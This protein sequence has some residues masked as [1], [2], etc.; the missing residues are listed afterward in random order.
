MQ[1]SIVLLLVYV[2]AA[3]GLLLGR[4]SG[5]A[6][7]NLKVTWGPNPFGSEYYVKQPLTID[8]AKNE[9]WVQVNNGCQGKFLGQRFVKDKDI[10]L[11]LI[12]GSNGHIAGVQMGI[13][14]SMAKTQYYKFDQQ[15]MFNRDTIAGIDAYI[16]TAY[17]VDPSTICQS[18]GDNKNLK[19]DAVGT[20]LWLQN[21]AD[22]IRDSFSSPLDQSDL[23]KTKWVQGACFP[24]MGVHYWYENRLD[25]D[26]D[27]F[28]PGFLLYTK[29]KLTGFG[30]STVGK[31]EYSKRTEFPPLAAIMSFLKP[32]PTCMPAQFNEVGG[33]T[34]MHLYFNAEPWSIFC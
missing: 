17:F 16:L 9:G 31:Y 24:S 6:W 29:G 23:P 34:T 10:A 2:T 25:A 14:A 5:P 11:V 4:G 15:K 12:Y 3:Y 20:G 19:N 27:T 22:P 8:D 18:T 30:W 7:N 13:P 1:L 28:F 26:C 33:F 32:V 21:G